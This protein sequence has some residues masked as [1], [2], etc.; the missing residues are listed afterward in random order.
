METCDR[1]KGNVVGELSITLD[2]HQSA[3]MCFAF[4]C[5]DGILNT[6]LTMSLELLLMLAE[7]W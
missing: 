2:D 6:A 1:I 7:I 4:A 3:N 5:F